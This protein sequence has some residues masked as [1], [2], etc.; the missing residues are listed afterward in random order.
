[1]VALTA[2]D[3][4]RVGLRGEPQQLVRLVL[5]AIRRLP[6]APGWGA[7][8]RDLAPRERAALE[9]AGFS[10]APLPG[11][12]GEGAVAYDPLAWTVAE[13][14]AL[15]ATA[16]PAPA[17]A[18]WLGV[19]ASR[20]RQRLAR[21]SLYGIKLADGWRLPAFQFDAPPPGRLVPGIERVLPHLDPALHPVGVYRWFTQP[22]PDLVV[23]GEPVSPLDW[24]RTGG[25][26]VEAAALAADL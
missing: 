21:R 1:M 5:E 19:D 16:W 12:I 17:A 9:R 8:E 7:P 2:D 18:R 15:L 11:A 14:T 23:V 25:D 4:E 3:L 10:F 20:V 24:L 26:P 13:Y 22:N 6:P